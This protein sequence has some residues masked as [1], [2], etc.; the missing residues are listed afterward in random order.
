MSNLIAPFSTFWKKWLNIKLIQHFQIF[1]QTAN[2]ASPAAADVKHTSYLK[3]FYI[4]ANRPI[5]RYVTL[6]YVKCIAL[7]VTL[8]HALCFFLHIWCGKMMQVIQVFMHTLHALFNI[9]TLY[10]RNSERH[11]QFRTTCPTS[12]Q[13]CLPIKPNEVQHLCEYL[14]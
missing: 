3:G 1:R 6:H 5:V 14:P 13:S 10:C 4:L 7:W 9:H 8:L 12:S 2:L 11:M